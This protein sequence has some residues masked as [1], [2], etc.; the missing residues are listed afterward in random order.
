[1]ALLRLGK[2]DSIMTTANQRTVEL[3]AATNG[4]LSGGGNE[5]AF[6]ARSAFLAE[7][8]YPTPSIP[9]TAEELARASEICR[10]FYAAEG[11]YGERWCTEWNRRWWSEAI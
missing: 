7:S 4:A 11:P 10:E 1:M 3:N 5:T 6:V 8:A 2:A 9:A